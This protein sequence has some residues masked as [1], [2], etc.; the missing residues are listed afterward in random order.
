[1]TNSA[2]DPHGV[3]AEA[4]RIVLP[5]GLFS[6][7]VNLLILTV[8]IYM[9][10][11]Y[12]RVLTSRNATTLVMLTLI[13]VCLVAVGSFLMHMRSRIE[14]RLGMR[15]EERFS[16]PAFAAALRRAVARSE[17]PAGPAADLDE[18]RRFLSGNGLTG[19]FDLPW[20]PLFILVIYVLH[21]LLGLVATASALALLAAN[22]FSRAWIHGGGAAQ[23]TAEADR[24]IEN[25]WRHGDVVTAMGMT[26]ALGESWQQ[27]RGWAAATLVQANDV[28]SWSQSITNFLRQL[29]QIGMLGLGAYLAIQ[30]IISPGTIVAGTII[31]GRALA[32][33]SKA[34]STVSYARGAWRAFARLRDADLDLLAVESMQPVD[35]GRMRGN[36][37]ADNVELAAADRG[38]P[39]L[40]AVS[41]DLKAGEA[42]GIVG[43]SGAGKSALA[44]ILAGALA[45]DGGRVLVDGYELSPDTASRI[46]GHVGYVP[47]RMA[48]FDGTVGQNIARFQSDHP[49]LIID[50]A[51]RAGLHDTV[52]CLPSAYNTP[53]ATA[54]RQMTAN[55]LRRIGL[56]RALYGDPAILVLDNPDAG[57][58]G[59]DMAAVIDIIRQRRRA[60]R[61]IVTIT[62]RPALIRE[63][64]WTLVLWNG[65]IEGVMEPERFLDLV[66]GRGTSAPPSSS[67]DG[68]QQAQ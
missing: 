49:D 1:M 61:T 8:P 28:L 18:L 48:L 29:A 17:A 50:A 35:R 32:P 52:E 38:Q 44:Q 33:V 68:L 2:T 6:I 7:F 57:L 63:M 36:L 12:D 24:F 40:K 15:L 54:A 11:I 16:R 25:S 51:S 62:E 5:I 58:D 14:V 30:D 42:L 13:A 34:P 67:A 64:D 43:P 19:L 53:M 65:A 23:E 46:G 56:A 41:F 27:R 55:Q 31:C 10:Q 21:P 39:A 3:A 9:L 60:G 22:L 20:V 66:D 59:E 45:P 37:I 47:K 4:R 26:G